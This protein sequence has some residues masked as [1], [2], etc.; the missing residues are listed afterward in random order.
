MTSD[1]EKSCGGKSFF[2]SKSGA[3]KAARHFAGVGIYKCRYCP[4]YHLFQ[5]TGCAGNSDRSPRIP[6]NC[7]RAGVRSNRRPRVEEEDDE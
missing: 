3:K 7:K 5:K 6:N 4:G 1:L 2:R